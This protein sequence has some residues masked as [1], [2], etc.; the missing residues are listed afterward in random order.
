MKKQL[1]SILG[2]SL[3]V[4]SFTGCQNKEKFVYKY[5]EN[6]MPD[7]RITTETGYV[8][9]Y[10]NKYLEEKDGNGLSYVEEIYPYEFER[11][12][13]YNLYHESYYR[14][15]SMDEMKEKLKEKIIKF[16]ALKEHNFR[17]IDINEYSKIISEHEE[18]V[19]EH[20]AL[21]LLKSSEYQVKDFD[22]FIKN[23]YK[24]KN[25]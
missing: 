3:L 22:E 4:F 19:K 15:I 12:N 17:W 14:Y 9:K 8:E 1:L 2:A 18:F 5:L 21:P 25:N 6:G 10:T 23:N 20:R 11:L 13:L 16:K 7:I 24:N